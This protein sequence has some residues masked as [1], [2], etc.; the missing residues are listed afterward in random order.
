MRKERKKC[1]RLIAACIQ[2]VQLVNF[3]SDAIH[4]TIEILYGWCIRIAE[5]VTQKPDNLKQSESKLTKVENFCDADVLKTSTLDNQCK[6]TTHNVQNTYL[7][8]RE[9]LPDRA[10][11]RTTNRWQF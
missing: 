6:L 2:N 4:F 5:F 3:A 10:E 7:A 8:T 1:H 9:D 11:P